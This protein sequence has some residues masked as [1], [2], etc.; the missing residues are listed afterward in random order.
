[1][2]DHRAALEPFTENCHWFFAADLEQAPEAEDEWAKSGIRA[3]E[4]F[5][6]V[7]SRHFY[8]GCEADDRAVA[9]AFNT[10][11]NP[12]GARLNALFSSDI[13]HWDVPDIAGVLA[14]AYELVD[15]ELIDEAD[16]RDFV[17]TNTVRLQTLNR[18]DF[19][20]G[21]AVE[22]AVNEFLAAESR[23]QAA[24]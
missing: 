9:G 16:F 15:D 10:K 12:F 19:F 17:F 21:T 6:R 3:D 20:E 4:D 8:F 2:P 1:M 7:F 22:D 23:A 18:P 13:G 5:A 11:A 14:E 24:E